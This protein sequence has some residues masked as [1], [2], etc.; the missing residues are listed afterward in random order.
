MIADLQANEGPTLQL[1]MLLD[2][3]LVVDLAQP[4][5]HPLDAPVPLKTGLG[6]YFGRVGPGIKKHP[7][8][9]ASPPVDAEA[10]RGW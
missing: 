4:L 2:A 5:F 1:A 6:T 8:T 10:G 9:V 7:S 3:G